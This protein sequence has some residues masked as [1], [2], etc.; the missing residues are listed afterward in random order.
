MGAAPIL[1]IMKDGEAVKSL[2]L[3]GESVL[4]RAE[5]CV[6]RLE[7][8]AIS[9]QHAVFRPGPNGV[10]VEKKS[11]FAPMLV[12]GAEA[13]TA[14]VKEGD[15]IHIG[16]Y[17]LRVSMPAGGSAPSPSLAP[18]PALVQA[19]TGPM[20]SLPPFEG[21]SEP[22][23]EAPMELPVE[24]PAVLESSGLE[25]SSPQQPSVPI[26]GMVGVGTE[27][28]QPQGDAPV[29]MEG[30]A[31]AE[32]GMGLSL[33]APAGSDAYQEPPQEFDEVADDARTKLT[34]AAKLSVH[35]VFAAGAAN[36]TDFEMTKDEVSIGRG[37]NCDIVLNDKK[38]SR[39][40]CIIR[41]AG[42]SF[43]IKDL[44]SAN[45]T[46]V[47]GS[48]ITEQ[49]LSGEDVIKIGST[50]FV[51]KALSSD[52]ASREK[53]FLALPIEEEQAAEGSELAPVEAGA[54]LMPEGDPQALMDPAAAGGLDLAGAGAATPGLAGIAG[55][56]GIGP[57]A[58][59]GGKKTLVERFKELPK[60]TQ[61]IAAALGLMVAWWILEEEPA[62]PPKAKVVQKKG[63][64]APTG[65]VGP[66]TFESLSP[67][68]QREVEHWHALA[69]DYF[70]NR[71]YD[72]ALFEVEKIFAYIPDYKDSKMLQRYAQ[73]GKRKLEQ[74]EEEK[75]KKE[76]EERLKAKIAQL[77]GEIRDKMEKKEY[78]QARELFPQLIAIDPENVEVAAWRKEIEQFEEDRKLK[79]AEKQVQSEIN[80]RAW[81]VYKDA[82]A[83]MKQGK[84][85]S[86]ITAF[87]KVHDI[88]ASDDRAK[89]AADKKIAACRQAIRDRREPVLA[90]ALEAEK[91]GDFGKAFKLYRRATVV[92]PPHP[93]GYAGIERIKGVLHDRAK[94]IYTEAVLAE[95]YS[96][97]AQA[98]AKYQQILT[99]AP[100]DDTYYGRAKR[101]LSHYF[102]EDGTP[103]Q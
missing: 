1:T 60:R 44:E 78:E 66:M 58:S 27:E 61:A 15:V 41:R 89:R 90:E 59:S 86:A 30:E 94:V 38:S 71:D 40:N 77:S 33:G 91:A 39:K 100:E 10:Q 2:P 68:K 84:F 13:T 52:Y 97:F 19:P 70:K 16:P 36:V 103:V 29:V 87:Q 6:I 35:L 75:R 96:D 7:D 80:Q 47:N 69:F 17:L 98:K 23:M 12:N 20:Q 95:S 48:K 63:A 51:F 24:P 42:L 26:E 8:R 4:G 93:A 82:L 32:G 45:G 101:K 64:T 55:I 49:E 73:E 92:D 28:M 21:G 102:K 57:G 34:P 50:E 25:E 56:A 74:I 62:P 3:E 85:H 31:P 5:G 53:G 18:E 11:E 99:F 43:I 79:E 14:L 88:G 67:D 46:Y 37:K 9:R 81:E 72:K 22:P 54:S 76:E 65:P 83:I